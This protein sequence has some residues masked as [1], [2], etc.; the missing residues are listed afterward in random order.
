MIPSVARIVRIGDTSDATE[1]IQPMRDDAPAPVGGSAS[2]DVDTS[3]GAQV[4]R[5]AGKATRDARASAAE[6]ARPV[7]QELSSQPAGSSRPMPSSP[8]L[9][10]AGM[11][12]VGA[13]AFYGR[14]VLRRTRT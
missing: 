10:L 5:D 12:A 6:S 7:M 14:R 13:T 8:A 2:P 4:A 1:A 11:A 3:A 9:P